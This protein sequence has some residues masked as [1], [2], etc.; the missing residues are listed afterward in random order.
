MLGTIE[1]ISLNTFEIIEDESLKDLQS[2][3]HPAHEKTIYVS[4]K[5]YKSLLA[6]IKT[7]TEHS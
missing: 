4:P 1:N 6:M 7:L 2:K 3:K 5:L